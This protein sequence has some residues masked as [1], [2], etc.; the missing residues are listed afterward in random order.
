[1]LANNQ[2]RK[3]RYRKKP[4]KK[5]SMTVKQ[6]ARIFFKSVFC[7]LIITGMSLIFIFGHD[8]LTQCDYFKAQVISIEG[9]ENMTSEQILEIAGIKKGVNILSVN[10]KTVRKKLMA[11]PCIAHA[12]VY[13]TFPGKI[14]LRIEEQKPIAVLDLGKRFLVNTSGIIYKEVS[15][16]EGAGMPVVCGIDYS[17]WKTSGMPS[18]QVFS[19]V[20][21]ILHFGISPDGIFPN[22]TIKYISVDREIGLTLQLDGPMKV[23]MLGYDNYRR[24][25]S[26]LAS[27]LTY[28]DQNDSIQGIEEIDIKNPDCI[29]ARP[30]NE[31]S[32]DKD[33]KEV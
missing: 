23:V 33:K 32:S 16:S 1:M 22:Q 4:V 12:D 11:N 13:R 9:A 17:D 2:L 19:S 6:M 15:E 10:L 21:E 29:V 25:Y 31:K 28:I 3:N 14:S 27:I 26:R 18:T 7:A 5:R 30:V 24:K 8:V 20:M